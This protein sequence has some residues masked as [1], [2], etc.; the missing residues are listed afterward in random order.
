MRCVL[1]LNF[2]HSNGS[3][4]LVY[5]QFMFIARCCGKKVQ[6]GLWSSMQQSLPYFVP[7]TVRRRNTMFITRRISNCQRVW[8]LVH[9]SNWSIHKDCKEHQASP[10]VTTLCTWILAHIGNCLSNFHKWCSCFTPQTQEGTLASVSTNDS[11]MQNREFQAGQRWSK[12]V[13]LL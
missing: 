7:S 1:T 11:S 10:L 5:H 9:D 6:G 3:G 12:F 8:R 13:I 2:H 4:N